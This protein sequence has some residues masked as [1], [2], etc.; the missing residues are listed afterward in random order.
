MSSE[1][2]ALNELKGRCLALKVVWLDTGYRMEVA[3]QRLTKFL[4]DAVKRP[5]LPEEVQELGE[6][7]MSIRS[8]LKEVRDKYPEVR[9]EFDPTIRVCD[10][11][12]API[13]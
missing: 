2:A 1:I 13:K 11:L 7:I 3:D 8:Y 9:G 4:N 10:W 6:E 5:L 12:V